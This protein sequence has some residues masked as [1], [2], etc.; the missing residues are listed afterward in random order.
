MIKI[1]SDEKPMQCYCERCGCNFTYEKEDIYK[2][3]FGGFLFHEGY[4]DYI[5]CPRC[6]KEIEIGVTRY[7]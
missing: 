6:G 3:Y 5:K 7:K 1:I 2:R 4:V